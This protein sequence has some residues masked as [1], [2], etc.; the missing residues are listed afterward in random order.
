MRLKQS[1]SVWWIQHTGGL[2]KKSISSM[3]LKPEIARYLN[4]SPLD[5]K[6]KVSQV[7]DWN[8]M[9]TVAV[10]R[11]PSLEKKSISSMRLKLRS[12]LW[13]CDLYYLEK[14]SISS[15][16]LKHCWGDHVSTIITD[17]K[18]KVSQVWDWNWAEHRGT[19]NSF[20]TWK[21]KYLKY[22]IETCIQSPRGT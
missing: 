17:L 2:E 5:L 16:R 7:W 1:V 21:E 22:E 9:F 8:A 20:L 14:K 4:R 10:V 3:R 18:R 13:V 12:W 19:K 11:S 15:M 6:R